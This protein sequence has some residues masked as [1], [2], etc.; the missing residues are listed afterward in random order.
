YGRCRGG[1]WRERPSRI[2]GSICE[3][4]ATLVRKL[5]QGQSGNKLPFPHGTRRCG[6]ITGSPKETRVLPATLL[7]KSGE[8][9]RNNLRASTGKDEPSLVSPSEAACLSR[10][11]SRVLDGG[12]VWLR[13]CARVLRPLTVC[14]GRLCAGERPCLSACRSARSAPRWSVPPRLRS[15]PR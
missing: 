11:R 12:G 5:F 7:P 10:D 4:A 8:R 15:W 14:D 2:P 13:K 9:P 3:L 6:S 1:K